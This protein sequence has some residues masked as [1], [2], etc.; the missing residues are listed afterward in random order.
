MGFEQIDDFTYRVPING[1]FTGEKYT[2]YAK[3]HNCLYYEGCELTYW[4]QY[5]D[6]LNQQYVYSI[7]P[8]FRD[9]FLKAYDKVCPIPKDPEIEN[10]F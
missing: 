2:E 9:Q 4:D 1:Y 3:W 7:K 10:D 6:N 5:I 8:E